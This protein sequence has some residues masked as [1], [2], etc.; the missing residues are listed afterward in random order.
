MVLMS[1]P[2]SAVLSK[3]AISEFLAAPA[4]GCDGVC[5]GDDG[6]DDGEMKS[7]AVAE[8]L[9]LFPLLLRSNGRSPATHCCLFLCAYGVTV[10][11]LPAVG[12]V[13][14]VL[15]SPATIRASPASRVVVGLLCVPRSPA[16][17]AASVMFELEPVATRYSSHPAYSSTCSPYF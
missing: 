7:L 9:L 12:S 2:R 14:T 15:G 5:G 17:P 4:V 10:S 13:E 6:D 11:G 3:P 1:L 16:V 8:L